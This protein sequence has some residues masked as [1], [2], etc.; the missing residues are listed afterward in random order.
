[1]MK[2]ALNTERTG[3]IEKVSN[4]VFE[5]EV[6]IPHQGQYNMNVLKEDLITELLAAGFTAEDF[7]VP[8]IQKIL[9]DAPIGYRFT[10]RGSGNANYPFMKINSQEL[11]YLNPNGLGGVHRIDRFDAIFGIDE[12][13]E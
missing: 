11:A 9:K 13:S 5:I 12:I 7:Q 8:D 3:K 10:R 2:S 1:M 6:S 4:K